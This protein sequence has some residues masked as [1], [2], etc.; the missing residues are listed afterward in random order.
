MS[1]L[2]D[3][4][5]IEVA[6][7]EQRLAIRALWSRATRDDVATRY[8][9]GLRLLLLERNPKMY[10]DN[11]MARLAEDLGVQ[12]KA[13][14]RYVAVAETWPGREV[15]ALLARTTPHGEPLS[16]PQL[17]ALASIDSAP[18]REQLTAECLAHSW[19]VGQLLV[20]IRDVVGHVDEDLEEV[21]PPAK[22]PCTL[23]EGIETASRATLDLGAFL[24]GLPEQLEKAFDDAAL[25]PQTIA[26]LE[27]LR[28]TV[29]SVLE[30][31]RRASHTSG[32]RMRA[33]G[34]AEE[35]VGPIKTTG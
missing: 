26:T 34:A 23:S 35:E 16:W 1:K 19:S 6:F 22:S 30:S 33:A 7:I 4:P 15:Q 25:L 8:Q 28:D 12:Q 32:T 31:I 24:D 10:G 2:S 9:L 27:E 11:A 3:A 5:A 20:R 14:S 17:V 21:A 18:V 29:D 13:L